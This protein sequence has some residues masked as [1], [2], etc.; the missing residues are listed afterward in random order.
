VT[1]SLE[2]FFRH[3]GY[4]VLKAFY[5][6]QALEQIQK[7]RPAVVILDLQMPG[8]NGLAVL[9]RIRK[10]YPEIKT[11]VITGYSEQYRKQLEGLGADVVQAKPV[12]LEK[13][14][15]AVEALIQGSELGSSGNRPS[16]GGQKTIRLLFVEGDD[17]IYEGL[18]KPYFES[19]ERPARYRT[20]LARDP[21]ELFRLLEPFRPHVVV[22]DST[23]LPVGVDTGRLAAD[24]SRGPIRPG[25]VILHEI[26]SFRQ[27]GQGLP[28][29]TERLDK[30]EEAVRRAA[31]KADPDAAQ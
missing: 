7:N 17:R 30:L 2:G 5:G 27:Q 6:D 25:E 28:V 29:L 14:T 9:E 21:E 20:V 26:P 12:S 1:L 3:R 10:E 15:G 8:L 31:G 24:L 22:M 16:A 4:Q 11:L 13:L 23:R 18:L 19:P